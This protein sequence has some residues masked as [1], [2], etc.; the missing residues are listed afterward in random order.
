MS[1]ARAW[2]IAIGLSALFAAGLFRASAS[3]G[4]PATEFL[5][6]LR[7]AGFH[8]VALEYLEKA[9]TSN[10]FDA[11]FKQNLQYETGVSLIDMAQTQRT[12]RARDQY[13]E[14]AIAEFNGFIKNNA[15]KPKINDARD[16][17]YDSNLYRAASRI[18]EAE[19]R[20]ADAARLI[21]EAKGFFGEAEKIIQAMISDADAAYAK[22]KGFDPKKDKDK[23]DDQR[24]ALVDVV[25]SRT[26]L[27]RIEYYRSRMHKAGSNEY[28]AQLK[29]A[30]AAYNKVYTEYQKLYY[31]GGL[32]ARLEEGR[33]Y[34]ELGDVKQAATIYDECLGADSTPDIL[35][36]FKTKTFVYACEVWIDPKVNKP[37]S[38]SDRGG[39]WLIQAR[40]NEA[41]DPDWL[42]LKYFVA[43]AK[44]EIVKKASGPNAPK[45][46]ANALSPAAKRA[47]IDDAIRI[48]RPVANIANPYRSQAQELL[49]RLGVQNP[50]DGEAPKSFAEARQHGDDLFGSIRSKIFL[51]DKLKEDLANPNNPPDEVKRIKAD[52]EAAEKAYKEMQPQALDYYR[53][54][55]TLARPTDKLDDV[56]SVRF[57][58]CLIYYQQDKYYEA[59]VIGEFL[60]R[61]YPRSPDGR[62]AAKIA[63]A[64]WSILNGSRIRSKEDNKFELARMAGVAHTILT[65]WTDKETAD[66][67]HVLLATIYIEQD[68]FPKAREHLDKVSPDCPKLPA[69][70]MSLGQALAREYFTKKRLPEDERP[71]EAELTKLMTDAQTLMEEGIKGMDEKGDITPNLVNAVYSLAQIYIDDSKNTK[72]V[73]LVEHARYGPLTLLKAN[74]PAVQPPNFKAPDFAIA[75][76]NLALR[77]YIGAIGDDP[78][79]LA[80][81]EQTIAA[82][83]KIVDSETLLFS[84]TRMAQELKKQL[85]AAPEAQKQ[86]IASGYMKFLVKMRDGGNS[87]KYDTLAYILKS[88][89]GLAEGFS[90]EGKPL[91]PQAKTYY[92]EAVATGEKIVAL[93]EAKKIEPNENAM[94]AV[95][96]VLAHCASRTGEYEKALDM[97]EAILGEKEYILSV[98]VDAAMAFQE[99]ARSDSKFY[100][101]ALN[102]GRKNTRTGKNT[103]WGWKRIS[104][105]AQR[106]AKFIETFHEAQYQMAVCY[107]E[108]GRATK[109]ERLHDRYVNFAK[110]ATKAI[111][112]Q[113]PTMGGPEFKARYDRLMKLAQK[114]LGESP[115]GLSEFGK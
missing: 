5:A 72:A 35:R 40:P 55:L 50:D 27:A 21:D 74:H 66:E 78:N 37:E 17:L 1:N 81:A 52:I 41:R 10:A 61:R 39:E 95:R 48:V 24:R 58:L 19:R 90:E 62:N 28:T 93:A 113:F 68:Q 88:F 108:L 47:Q 45:D 6:A 53:L 9:K 109:D 34:Q 30:A 104:A 20:T 57:R 91:S 32:K 99:M 69:A 75:T 82:L 85:A 115:V 31:Y 64:S 44:E 89:E 23:Q 96:A 29:K 73:P 70:K 46:A 60:L 3:A 12:D 33:C 110:T 49:D 84:Y 13:F 79:L 11:E 101:S 63:L 111:Y 97:Y 105:A 112:T 8:D 14:R 114:E 86:S 80:K 26:K 98:Q 102:G 87:E 54:A 18:D 100:R 106:N 59:A 94:L 2:R 56:N 43:R 36:D 25:S 16:R 67:T 77:A 51:I 65:T 71:D 76:Y 38:A 103:I 22:F 92:G 107:F 7:Q 15:G 83:E 4:E 42:A